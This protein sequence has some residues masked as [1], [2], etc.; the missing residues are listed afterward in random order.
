MAHCRQ[1]PSLR[2]HGAFSP[3]ERHRGT[4]SL[5]PLPLAAPPRLEVVEAR[6][7]VAAVPPGDMRQAGTLAGHW[8]AGCLL[9]D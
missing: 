9:T 2:L 3:L 4:P 6:A 8:V 1:S 5:T 7:A